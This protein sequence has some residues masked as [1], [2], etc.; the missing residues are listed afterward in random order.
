MTITKTLHER[1]KTIDILRGLA[2]FTMIAANMIPGLLRDTPSFLFRLY[3]SFAAPIFIFLSGMMVSFTVTKGNHSAPYFIKRTIILLLTGAVIDLFITGIYPFITFDVLYLIGASTLL[4]FLFKKLKISS[5][6]ILVVIIFA[7]TPLLQG[8]IGYHEIPVEIHLPLIGENISIP[9][10]TILRQWFIDGWFPLFPWLGFAFLGSITSDMRIK[11]KDF[12][13]LLILFIGLLILILGEIIW[14][15]NPGQMFIRK[16]YSELFYPPTYGFILA[17]IGIII[18]LF[19]IIDLKSSLSIYKPF[20][21]LGRWSLQI[22]IIHLF[23]ISLL[24]KVLKPQSINI[25]LEIYIGIVILLL[26]LCNLMDKYRDRINKK[27][28]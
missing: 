26:G 9:I 2:I 20:S 10:M 24:G 27:Y 3:G 17:S 4:T 19:Y 14:N 16:G 15:I 18:I 6:Y 21:I 5:Q 11:Y 1:D 7:L 12:S 8:I 22:Y 25:F 23:I 13:N 28:D